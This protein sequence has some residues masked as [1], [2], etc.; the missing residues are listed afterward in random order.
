MHGRAVGATSL[1]ENGAP[2]QVIQRI[3]HSRAP[4]SFQIYI[5]KHTPSHTTH[6]T[7]LFDMIHLPSQ[8]LIFTS[9]HFSFSYHGPLLTYMLGHFTFSCFT[10]HI[11]SIPLTNQEKPW[12]YGR[13]LGIPQIHNRAPTTDLRSPQGSL[14]PATHTQEALFIGLLVKAF[15]EQYNKIANVRVHE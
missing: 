1:T 15:E 14:S 4:I 3:G 9:G 8:S 2:P 6:D 7:I 11:M 5:W 13:L 10:P 12:A